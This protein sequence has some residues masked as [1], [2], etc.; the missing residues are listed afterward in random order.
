MYLPPKLV[1]A[2]HTLALCAASTAANSNSLSP[3][4]ALGCAHET[5]TEVT[6]TKHLPVPLVSALQAES[7]PAR[8]MADREEEWNNTDIRGTGLPRTRFN[9]ARI[10]KSCAFVSYLLGGLHIRYMLLVLVV[11]DQD[12][13]IHHHG[14]FF[15]YPHA[16]PRAN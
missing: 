14:I 1:R 8:G 13:T 5:F 3:D 12:W 15:T 6:T 10:G 7:S 4:P 16:I 9:S 2:L 11:R